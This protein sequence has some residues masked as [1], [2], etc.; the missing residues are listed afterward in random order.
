[1]NAC[2]VIK[3]LAVIAGLFVFQ[4]VYAADVAGKC[5][6][7][8]IDEA[9]K[10]S[11]VYDGN[12]FLVGDQYV[13]LAGVHVPSTSQHLVPP[14]PLGK[15]VAEAVSELIKR[16]K[17]QLNIE[18]DAL[19][20]EK[21]KVL[22]HAY[23]PDGRNLAQVLLENGFALVETALPNIKHAQCYREAEARARQAKKGLWQFEDKGVPVIESKD[24]SQE[25]KGF[26]IVRGKIVTAQQGENYF[27]LNMDTVGFRIS[28]DAMRY[29]NVSDLLSLKGKTVEIRDYLTYYKGHT[30]ALLDHAGQIDLLADKFYEQM[31]K[32]Q[33]KK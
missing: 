19:R 32:T 5:A 25:R 28:K 15:A 24:I 18:Y 12:S 13:R 4:P 3:G 9:V 22:V 27:I 29:F 11:I 23:L 33:S 8:K 21:G 20:S 30:F 2:Q 26:Q 6:P 16:A 1:M 10:V 14:E 7:D 31:D 17:G